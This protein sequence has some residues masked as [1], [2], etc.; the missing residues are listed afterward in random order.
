MICSEGKIIKSIYDMYFGTKY[1]HEVTKETNTNRWLKNKLK[2]VK[3]E[4]ENSEVYQKMKE[5]K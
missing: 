5:R 1:L 2:K 3:N 4:Y